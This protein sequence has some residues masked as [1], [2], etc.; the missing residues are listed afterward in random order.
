MKESLTVLF[1]DGKVQK[2]DLFQTVD[3]LVKGFQTVDG[4]DRTFPRC[5]AGRALETITKGPAPPRLP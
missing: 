5:F 4:L 2:R 3:D 1:M